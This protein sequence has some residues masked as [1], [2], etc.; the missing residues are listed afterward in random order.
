MTS[1]EL[2]SALTGALGA[3]LLQT[4]ANDKDV[5]ARVE[6]SAWRRAAEVC[7]SELGF[8]YFCFISGIDWLPNP[9]LDGEKAFVP[10]RAQG[11]AP[12]IVT[13]ETARKAGG[14]SRFQVIARIQRTTAHLG[15][16]LLS[17]LDELQ[18][19]APSW[20]PVYRGADWH[21]R[22]TWEM[23]GFD[24]PGH[25]GLRHIYLPSEFE[26]FPLRKDFPLL[27]RVVRPW[28][29]LVDMEDLPV[30]GSDESE[31]AT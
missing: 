31:P 10:N 2:I 22:E 26:G 4:D 12:A 14:T 6:A 27:A 11:E 30:Q 25:P 23:F 21:E 1:E 20:V 16:I 7:K 3:D 5:W 18:P 17:D 24:F 15:L 19:A 8:D 9:D 13:D 28:P 29:G